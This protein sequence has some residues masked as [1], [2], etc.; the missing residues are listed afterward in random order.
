MFFRRRRRRFRGV[1]GKLPSSLRPKWYS[2]AFIE[3]A[4]D[5]SVGPNLSELVLFDGPTVT[6]AAQLEVNR[7]F[8]VRRTLFNGVIQIAESVT[9]A[10]QDIFSIFYAIY[11]IDTDD[12]DATLL[13]TAVGGI[14]NSQRVI[15]TG[16]VGMTGV[17][18]TGAT[19]T[20]GFIPSLPLNID[21][22]TNVKLRED[23]IL[24]LGIQFT[25]TNLA[26]AIANVSGIARVLITP[27]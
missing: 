24:A 8:S 15:H 18:L 2:S 16:C 7:T 19:P 4:I 22:R 9:A 26:L 23:E 25:S 3:T 12:T 5:F 10:V 17:E 20:A 6:S 13:N 1:R 21:V 27:P 11:V 14:L